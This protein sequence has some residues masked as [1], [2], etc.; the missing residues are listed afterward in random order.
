MSNLD[1]LNQFD[2]P[3]VAR[4]DFIS[5][6]LIGRS[7][8]RN[9]TD[10]QM[11]GYDKGVSYRFFVTPVKNEV[12]SEECDM[13]INDEVKMI[14][15]FVNRKNKITERVRFLPPQL[16]KFNKLGECTGGAYKEAYLRF[17]AGLGVEGLPISRWEKA[18]VAQVATLNSEGIHT[19]EQF[20]AMPRDRVEGRFPKE[21][22]KLFHE[23]V[24][25]VNRNSPV[26][27]D[28]EKHAAEIL[29][30]K[31]EN[32]KLH[33]V[34]EGLVAQATKAEKKKAKSSKLDETSEETEQ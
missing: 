8:D 2:F 14:E 4:E 3:Q 10:F 20:A 22:V 25:F 23:A 16:L 6:G 30:L 9:V 18:S 28:M 5:K 7:V 33:T 31:Q 27:Q 32:A 24:Q 26:M 29:A 12:K 19:V 15:W 21:L 11:A 17:E 1:L 34:V 13:E